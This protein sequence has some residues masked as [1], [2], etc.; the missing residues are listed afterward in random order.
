MFAQV[1]K[2]AMSQANPFSKLFHQ[3][4]GPVRLAILHPGEHD[5]P[6][7]VSLTEAVPSQTSYEC[8]SYN[9]AKDEDTID[10][11]VDDQSQPI[12][13][14]LESGLRILRRKE[15]PRTLWADLL[16]GSSAEERSKQANTM[17]MILE[18]AERT[19]CWTGTDNDKTVR[20][21]DTI[22]EMGKRWSQAR[23]EFKMPASLSK[24]TPQQMQ[25]VVDK[26]Q[27]CPY[28]DLDSFN[29]GHWNEIYSV[30]GTEYWKSV[31]CISDIVLAKKAI[32]ICG[33]SNIPWQDYIA[34]TWALPIFQGKFFGGVPLLPSVIKNLEIIHSIAVADRR[35]REGESIELMP[36][37]M[38]ARDHRPKDKRD[39]VFSML[40]IVTPSK[41]L[42][43]HNSEKPVLPEIDYSKSVEEVFTEATKYI[44]LER[45]DLMLWWSE[46]QPSA[47]KIK[48]LPSWVPDW[49]RGNKNTVTSPYNGL[50][51]WSDF[52]HNESPKSITISANNELHLQVRPIDRISY[53][54]PIFHAGNYRRLALEELRKLP[55]PTTDS[56]GGPES[57]EAR[58][59]RFWRTLI[60]NA[61]GQGQTLATTGQPP[62]ELGNNFRSL[63]A[64]EE[65]LIKLDCTME[66]L[67]TPEVMARLDRN[68]LHMKS[69]FMQAGKSGDYTEQMMR[70]TLGRRFFITEMGS[71]G[72]TAVE[73]F[74]M[75]DD[76]YLT[77]EEGDDAVEEGKEG[78]KNKHIGEIMS[79]PLARDMMQAF[80]N[81][82]RSKGDAVPPEMSQ[83]WE[84]MMRGEHPHQKEQEAEKSRDFGAKE[85]DLIV[86]CVGG[87]FPYIL[88]P[89]V[90]S[91]EESS[92]S[93]QEEETYEYVG[94]CFLYG[95]MDGEC[96]QFPDA[97]GRAVWDPASSEMADIIVV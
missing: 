46:R 55:A 61:Y 95:A 49:S 38:T 4:P 42:D 17:R 97:N 67:Q 62:A 1:R 59:E 25:S 47:K 51:S 75:L 86:A 56:E 41:R 96:F 13:K 85:G 35:R 27:S 26:L 89:K 48:G 80:R 5:A 60:S 12:P 32:V 91:P 82:L 34:A 87:F 64:E 68:D 84:K 71:F 31:Q 44:I 2:L 72:M 40:P 23:E 92:S 77:S 29:F 81:H 73:N 69:L 78:A 24:A 11:T 8:L 53:L 70:A 93:A 90:T 66:E 10:I 16:I 74:A 43:Y 14:H 15:R 65:I 9:R 76:P 30:F 36:M 6:I 37:I 88:R 54:S 50:R 33:R 18:N 19:L 7:K 20:A 94:D 22:R 52:A 21:Y 57:E 58:D 45:Q 63:L 28:N 3:Q 83:A 79:S 39:C